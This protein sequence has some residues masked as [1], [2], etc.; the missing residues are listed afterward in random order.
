VTDNINVTSNAR[1]ILMLRRSSQQGADTSSRRGD[2]TPR[3]P[4]YQTG[5]RDPVNCLQNRG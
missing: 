2:P 3:K 5:L 4:H 1:G